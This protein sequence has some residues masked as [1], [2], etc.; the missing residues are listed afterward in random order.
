MMSNKLEFLIS[1]M[2]KVSLIK[3]NIAYAIENT[4]LHIAEPGEKI[5]RTT[6][7]LGFSYD[8]IVKV[9]PGKKATIAGKPI[10]VTYLRQEPQKSS[11]R[12]EDTL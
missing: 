4:V 5:K 6:Y 11:R 2:K 8:E 1:A 9:V 7:P 12:F 3:K 10:S